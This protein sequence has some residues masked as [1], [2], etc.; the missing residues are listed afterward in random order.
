MN[1]ERDGRPQLALAE[2]RTI[3]A[4]IQ[5]HNPIQA[6]AAMEIHKQRSR[7]QSAAVAGKRSLPK[8][9]QNPTT[10]NQE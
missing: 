5:R 6:V 9:R 10:A 7:K 4:T 1:V 2:Q 8:A 3:V